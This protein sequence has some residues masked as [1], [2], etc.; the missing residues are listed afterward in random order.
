M[1]IVY[2]KYKLFNIF[3]EKQKHLLYSACLVP[4]QYFNGHVLIVARQYYKYDVSIRGL[5]A[6]FCSTVPDLCEQLK[7][8]GGKLYSSPLI[9]L[10]FHNRSFTI[11]LMIAYQN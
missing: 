3:Y 4:P 1:I 8:F 2:R 11:Y 10:L 6:G 7:W 9:L 5:R